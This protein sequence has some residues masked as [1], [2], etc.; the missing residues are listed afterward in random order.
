MGVLGKPFEDMRISGTNPEEGLQNIKMAELASKRLLE[1]EPEHSA[2]YVFLSDI[3]VDVGRW[4]DVEKVI[5]TM[6]SRGVKKP[7]G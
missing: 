6:K 3:C 2:S 4:S 7:P 1:L 5:A